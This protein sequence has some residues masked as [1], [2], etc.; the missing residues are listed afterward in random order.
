VAAAIAAAWSFRPAVHPE[1]IDDPEHQRRF[2]AACDALPPLGAVRVRSDD[3]HAV[4]RLATA[5]GAAIVEVSG[6]ARA[7]PVFR[8]G[9]YLLATPAEL[10]EALARLKRGELPP[11]PPPPP[12]LTRYYRDADGPYTCDA[13]LAGDATPDA[14]R[15][16]L[17]GARLSGEPLAREAE[18]RDAPRIARTLLLALPLLGGWLAWRRGRVEAERRLLAAL[19][20][21]VALGVTGLGADSL[22][23]AALL[24]VAGAPAGSPLLAG[25]PCLLFP[26]LAL[27]RLGVVLLVGGVLCLGRPPA[28]EGRGSLRAAALAVALGV[29]GFLALDAVPLGAA[30]RPEVAAEPAALLVPPREVAATAAKLRAEGFDVVGDEDLVPQPADLA[31]RRALDRIFTLA[32]RHAR[33]AEGELRD[34]FADVADAASRTDLYLP[35][36]LRARLRARDGRHALWLAGGAPPAAASARL[37]RERG[38]LSRREHARAAGVAVLL[39]LG[40]GRALVRGARPV[41]L[42]F[43]GAAAGVLLLLAAAPDA[44]DG[45]VPLVAVAAAA[46]AFGPPLAL[47]AA[48]IFDPS[49]LLPA[50]ALFV[51]AAVSRRSLRSPSR[52]SPASSA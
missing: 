49:T 17:P 12:D 31:R 40:L 13:V 8:A 29:A 30:S 44:A 38:D 39:A 41:L 52:P 27:K 9:R 2:L 25:A 32:E 21:L 47:A 46:P 48:A 10:D 4:H 7:E 15:R 28:R 19:A 3:P 20:A 22:T 11:P 16:V 6:P 24:L 26:P 33:G 43:L 34:R 18:A 42:A 36:S 1:R 37:Y 45:F 14:I 35:T 51:A 5:P 23:V 50:A